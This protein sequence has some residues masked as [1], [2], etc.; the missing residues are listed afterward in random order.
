MFFDKKK[1]EAKKRLKEEIRQDQVKAQE[2]A[3]E[4]DA[5]ADE[6]AGREASLA[7]DLRG[8]EEVPSGMMAGLKKGLAKTKS[9]FTG[10]I[11][12]MGSEGQAD[13][14][15]LEELEERL[16]SADLGVATCMK[17]ID[18]L[19]SKIDLGQIKT[20]EE[21]ISA[22]KSL[23]SAILD[24]GDPHLAVAPSGPSVYLFVGVNGVGKT[25]T[26]GKLAAQYKAEGKKV[27]VAAGDTLPVEVLMKSAPECMAISDIRLTRS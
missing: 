9:I 21:A 3:Q 20:Q 8:V 18:H 7:K 22:L 14:E 12:S 1:K 17:I 26:I 5:K 16:L 4:I 27:L 19:K 2:I 24:L 25:T 11:L 6:L 15:F 23:I 10:S 13:E